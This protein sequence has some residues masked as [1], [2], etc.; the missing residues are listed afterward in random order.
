MKSSSAN[1][2]SLGDIIRIGGKRNPFVVVSSNVFNAN[3][4]IFYVC[5]IVQDAEM[6]PFHVKI[7]GKNGTLGIAVCENVI[8]INP[9]SLTIKHEDHIPY[10]QVIEI[11][12]IL[13]G[14][15]EYD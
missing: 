8:P 7:E 12:D 4:I 14:I 11:S 2:V 9:D 15:F 6:G 1:K 10:A 13:Q 5:P 3:A